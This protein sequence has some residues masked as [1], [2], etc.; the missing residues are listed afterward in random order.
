MSSAP[1]GSEF[2]NRGH[3]SC[4]TCFLHCAGLG[5]EAGAGKG[6][7]PDPRKQNPKVGST[8]PSVLES[9]IR[10]TGS[11]LSPSI[12]LLHPTHLLQKQ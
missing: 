7:V 5:S 9:P 3:I 6:C 10:G 1:W 8:E 4:L 11:L 2:L 12:Y